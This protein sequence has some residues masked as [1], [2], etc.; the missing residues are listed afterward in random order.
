MVK[1]RHLKNKHFRK[2]KDSRLF[3]GIHSFQFFVGFSNLVDFY[4]L[5][6]CYSHCSFIT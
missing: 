6:V 4:S 2:N 3:C 5:L 1:D